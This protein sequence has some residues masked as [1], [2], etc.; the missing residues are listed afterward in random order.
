MPYL[1]VS[2]VDSFSFF[3]DTTTWVGIRYILPDGSGESEG[4]AWGFEYS[5]G[6]CVYAHG[7]KARD[8]HMFA[9]ENL[10]SKTINVNDDNSKA[11]SNVTI[12]GGKLQI[13]HDFHPSSETSNLYEISIALENISGNNIT[14]V[15]YRRSI[16]FD[17]SP[18]VRTIFCLYTLLPLLRDLAYATIFL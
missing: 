13:I 11:V 12:E 5:E 10:A 3:H 6:W 18:T 16:D 8:S 7:D 2:C 14:D 4:A 9:S 15:R 17:P 1:E